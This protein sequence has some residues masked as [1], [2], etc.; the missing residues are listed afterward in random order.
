MLVKYDYGFIIIPSKEA[1]F[2]LLLAVCIVL[3]SHIH[4]YRMCDFEMQM[5]CILC[6]FVFLSVF[7]QMVWEQSCELVIMLTEVVESGKVCSMLDVV[8]QVCV[9][10]SY[11]VSHSTVVLCI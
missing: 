5:R 11:C 4:L 6:D 2:F 10:T 1:L 8:L 9:L 7:H 3:F